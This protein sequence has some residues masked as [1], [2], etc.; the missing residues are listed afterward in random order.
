MTDVGL[1]TINC[2]GAVLDNPCG[3]GGWAFVVSRDAEIIHREHGPLLGKSNN[4][5]EYFAILQALKWLTE[6]AA[7]YPTAAI[8]SD[9]MLAISQITGEW[10]CKAEHLERLR[11]QCRV[12]AAR[13]GSPIKFEWVP[14]EMNIEADLEASRGVAEP[15]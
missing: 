11:D 2:D 6:H 15:V 9:S 8:Y 13:A 1:L 7:E 5:A 3:P 10:Q 14:R 4:E 12:L